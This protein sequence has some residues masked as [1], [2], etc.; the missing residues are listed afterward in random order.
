[1]LFI[2]RVVLLTPIGPLPIHSH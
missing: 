2:E 1:M